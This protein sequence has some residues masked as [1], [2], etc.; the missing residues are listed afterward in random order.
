[1]F[2]FKFLIEILKVILKKLNG[3]EIIVIIKF[4]IGIINILY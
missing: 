1:M 4:D 3:K 2:I